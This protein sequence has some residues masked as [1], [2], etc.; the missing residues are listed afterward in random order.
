M[1]GNLQGDRSSNNVARG[2]A[3]PWWE[4][5]GKAS[6]EVG[7]AIHGTSQCLSPGLLPAS[8][9][10]QS[11]SHL[12][13]CPRNSC[14]LRALRIVCRLAVCGPSSRPGPEGPKHCHPSAKA[15]KQ[16]K[17]QC[18]ARALPIKPTC[19]TEPAESQDAS[20]KRLQ[21]LSQL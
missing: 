21:P 3:N 18:I 8:L 20:R 5:Q 2:I 9:Q 14:R 15:G 4:G 17:K 7:F 12:C 13:Q 10:R 19:V 11:A 16:S 1:K 6:V